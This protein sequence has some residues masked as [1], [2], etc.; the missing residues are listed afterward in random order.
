MLPRR[1]KKQ[2]NERKQKEKSEHVVSSLKRSD[3]EDEDRRRILTR[4]STEEQNK[5]FERW[6]S[7]RLSSYFIVS[8]KR[9]LANAKCILKSEFN[10]NNKVYQ[11]RCIVFIGMI[12]M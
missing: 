11:M 8:E 4:K 6:V 9:Q 3:T 1:A 2:W 12:K 5:T 10:I 7:I